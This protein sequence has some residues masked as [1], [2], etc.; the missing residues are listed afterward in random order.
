VAQT[1]GRILNAPWLLQAMGRFSL[2]AFFR[3]CPVGLFMTH[4][5]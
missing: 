5:P 4:A 1:A 3:R 2:S